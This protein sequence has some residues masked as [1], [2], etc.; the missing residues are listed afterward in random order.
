MWRKKGMRTQKVN[1]QG[2]LKFW[3]AQTDKSGQGRN[4]SKGGALTN[5]RGQTGGQV[6]TGKESERARG[7]HGLE[8]ADRRTSQDREGIRASEGHSRAGEGRQTDK[9]GQGRN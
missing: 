8:R 4:P 2:A 5:W 1:E 9:S 7:T 6:R 3:R